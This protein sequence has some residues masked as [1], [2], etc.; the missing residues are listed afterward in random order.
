LQSGAHNNVFH[1][2]WIN[3]RARDG[4]LDGVRTQAL[5]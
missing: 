1:L 2:G 4:M 3:T 5:P